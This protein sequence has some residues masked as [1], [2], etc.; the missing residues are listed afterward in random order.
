MVI[1][2][3]CILIISLLS[4]LFANNQINLYLKFK[5][6]VMHKIWQLLNMILKV[7]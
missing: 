5:K 6:M 2:V 7:W 3:Y 4:Y 1:Y